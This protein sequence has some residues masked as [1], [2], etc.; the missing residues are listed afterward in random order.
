MDQQDEEKYIILDKNVKVVCIEEG[1]V[2]YKNINEITYETAL[3]FWSCNVEEFEEFIQAIEKFM[4]EPLFENLSLE[5]ISFLGIKKD[6]NGNG[7]IL[8]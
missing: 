3:K 5:G 1:K 2:V 8:F 4:N 7:I 6:D